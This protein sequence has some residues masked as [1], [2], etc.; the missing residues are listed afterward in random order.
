[1]SQT[2]NTELD[3]LAV[4]TIKFLA[5]DGV[6]KAKS[7][8]PGLPMGAA[9]FAYVLWSRFLKYNPEDP[10]WPN[11]DRFVL[12]AGH[13]SMLLYSLLHLAGFDMPMEELQQFRQ[14]GSAT[15]GH[16]EY[17]IERGIETT[18]GPLGQGIS[19]AVGMAMASKR[20]AALFNRPGYDIIDHRVYVLAS[21]GDLMEGVSHESC[22]LAG[23]LGLGNLIVLYDDNHITIEGDTCLSCSDDA[24]GRFES[25]NWHVQTVDGHDRGAV[26]AAISA[27]I[28][29]TERPSI[30]I[31][32]TR[33]ASGAPTKCGTAAAHG[34]PLGEQE[35]RAAKELVGWP[36]DKPFH[37]PEVVRSLFAERASQLKKEYDAWQ[38]MF[39]K[40]RESFPEMDELWNRMMHRE[41]PPALDDTLLAALDCAKPNATRNSSGLVIQELA[42]LVPALWGGS[43]DLAPSNKT[44]VKGGGEFLRDDP[45]GRNLHFGIREH[46]MGSIMNGM[47]LYGGVIPYGGTFLVFADYMRPAIRLASLMKQQV[48][49]VFTHDSI[50]V[51]E[52][53]PTHEPIEHLASLRAIPGL[54]VIRPADTAETAIAWSVALEN[55]NG[56]T[57]LALTRQNV[58]PV[59]DDPAKAKGLRRGAYVVRDVDKI[60]VILIATGSEVGTAAG[61]AELLGAKGIGARVVSMPS[62]ELF[63]AQEDSYK[64]AVLPPN[65]TKRVVIEAASPFGWCKY[66][67]DE[68][69]VIGMERFGASAPYKVLAEK[70]GFTPEAVAARVAQYLR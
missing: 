17:D 58:D 49:Y 46:G 1:M 48:I 15:P 22:S 36:V 26:Q 29:E 2:T 30:I 12:S 32:R 55:K 35:V 45:L 21:D 61:A 38:A 13:G 50:F 18:T 52:D 3:E 42:K 10:T 62:T 5:V 16:P 60:D 70:F 56:P 24:A 64:D 8:H 66:A 51:G 27:A 23:H 47:A 4:R 7:G 65:I 41:V 59:N 9:D 43:A 25:Y 20:L 54:T 57:A 63:D 53:G 14:W 37:V 19:N 39:R 34:E 68:G 67:G 40:Y 33:I 28:A 69:L 31:A 6:E 44:D 11:R